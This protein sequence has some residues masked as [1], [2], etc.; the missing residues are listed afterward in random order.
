MFFRLVDVE[1]ALT[2]RGYDADGELTL[3]VTADRETPWNEGT[4][5][6]TVAAGQAEVSKDSHR[7]DLTFTLKSLA[8]AFSGFRRVRQLANW[9]LV[10]GSE[11]AIARADVLF[12][13]RYAPHSPDHF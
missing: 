11:D 8:S 6:L 1:A 2:G 7:P 12:A 3:G 4:Y 13:T 5:R 10:D 9:G